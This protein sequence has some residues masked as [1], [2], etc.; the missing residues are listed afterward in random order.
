MP[1][2]RN[3]NVIFTRQLFSTNGPPCFHRMC[4]H[5]CNERQWES[6]TTVHPSKVPPNGD[7]WSV[8]EDIM[9]NFGSFYVPC[10]AN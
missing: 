8:S 3:G 4:K 10:M 1:H 6:E 7:T 5:K 2:H 9:T